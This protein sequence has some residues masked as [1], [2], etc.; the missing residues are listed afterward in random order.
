MGEVAVQSFGLTG[1]GYC[2]PGTGACAYQSA[3]AK[4]EPKTSMH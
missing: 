3:W 4:S 2:V 1:T